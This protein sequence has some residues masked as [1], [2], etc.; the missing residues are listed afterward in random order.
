[1]DSPRSRQSMLLG[2]RVTVKV[3]A[4]EIQHKERGLELA[5]LSDLSTTGEGI[6][7]RV[8]IGNTTPVMARMFAWN[9]TGARQPAVKERIRSSVAVQR[10]ADLAQFSPNL[11]A[12]WLL[13][14][15]D[16]A[17]EH[18]Y[19]QEVNLRN[20]KVLFR[21]WLL[22]VSAEVAEI[23]MV[24]CAMTE[25]SCKHH[26]LIGV[27]FPA[28]RA[29][30]LVVW[31]VLCAFWQ[32]ST[33]SIIV[34]CC[35]C[36][37]D[38]V[39][40]FL[41]YLFPCDGMKS[42]PCTLTV[43]MISM[44]MANSFVHLWVESRTS[45][46]WVLPLVQ[47]VSCCVLTYLNCPEASVKKCS[48][49]T[50]IVFLFSATCAGLWYG[51][52]RVELRER[53]AWSERRAIDHRFEQQEMRIRENNEIARNLA[54]SLAAMQQWKD[55]PACDYFSNSHDSKQVPKLSPATTYNV[56]MNSQPNALFAEVMGNRVADSERIRHIA[57]RI[58]DPEYNLKQYWKDCGLAFPELA[59]FFA[60]PAGAPPVC[61]SRSATEEEYQRTVAAFFAVYWLL[62]IDV[63]GK[64]DPDEP[65]MDDIGHISCGKSG[66]SFG[67][68]ASLQ[69]RLLA[70][71]DPYALSKIP[72]ASMTDNQK[73]HAFCHL[74]DWKNIRQLILLAGLCN[75]TERVMA[76]LALTAFHDIMKSR[77]LCPA[78]QA[79]HAPYAGYNEGEVIYDHDL[80]LAYVLDHFGQLLPSFH[81]LSEDSKRCIRFSQ[82]KMQFNHGWFV[83][84]EAPPGLMLQPLKQALQRSRPGDMAFYFVHWLTDLAGAEGTPL[85]GAEKLAVKFPTPVLNEFLR[86]IPHLFN[87]ERAT[88]VWV[89]E[90]YLEARWRRMFPGDPVPCGFGRIAV[91]RLTIAAQSNCAHVATLFGAI[92]GGATE[93]GIGLRLT[94]EDK[95]T[96]AE[97]MA[98]T[99]LADQVYHSDN[100]GQ[101]GPAFLIYYGPAVLQACKTQRQVYMALHA[102][103]AVYRAGREL[104]PIEESEDARNSTVTLDVAALKAMDI[105]AV[106][107]A[108]KEALRPAWVLVKQNS[109]SA[110]VRFTQGEAA[111]SSSADE[112][113]APDM[114]VV[115]LR[116]EAAV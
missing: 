21:A 45:Q 82:S 90:S 103:A 66:L 52:Y 9:V 107:R 56:N 34:F 22:F 49:P 69:R 5:H 11:R 91:M 26:I 99:G 55:S 43:R 78:V 85:G 46:S 62:R 30:M 29:L 113:Y 86:S 105:D 112:P 28:A 70:E 104:W 7:E 97:E 101:F 64:Q 67:V 61:A 38:N 40:V 53:L 71:G 14:F 65:G 88:E 54:E 48:V 16:K 106:F 15:E 36:L 13:C 51:R 35:F 111:T 96:L 41:R 23:I 81:C 59:L 75:S 72:F 84:A 50:A 4:S 19:R 12:S 42:F 10:Y 37:L 98:C 58:C 74:T 102:L 100:A 116:P 24:F 79:E 63:A 87:L 39:Q 108:S 110:N 77:H 92:E 47:M 93:P 1:M 3:T 6:L 25:E 95:T 2:E 32:V 73:R 114:A 115:D 8:S 44:V 60:I 57:S 27:G 76:L 80:A 68:D 31:W 33:V 109:R 20:R 83:Q 94:G 17:Q 18:V 89:A